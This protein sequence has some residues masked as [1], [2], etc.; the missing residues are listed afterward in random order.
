MI[1][2]YITV[3]TDN[4]EEETI[5]FSSV[6]G[7]K[8]IGEFELWPNI[9][10]NLLSQENNSVQIALVPSQ[11]NLEG[12]SLV[13]LNTENCLQSFNHIRKTDV[14]LVSDPHYSPAGMIGEFE[15]A[16]GNH[17]ILLEERIYEEI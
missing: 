13:I 11:A 14:K 6:L 15:D 1:V 4:I 10:C 9:L 16:S 2:K 12:K 8:L 5:F 17:F 3:Q 7:F